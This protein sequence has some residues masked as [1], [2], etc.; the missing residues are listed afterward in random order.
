MIGQ[1]EESVLAV[2]V[3]CTRRDHFSGTLRIITHFGPM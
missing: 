2:G 3:L 1:N